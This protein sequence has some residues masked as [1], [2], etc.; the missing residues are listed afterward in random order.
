MTPPPII[1]HTRLV[2]HLR[3]SGHTIT[4]DAALLA[5]VQA[6][7]AKY[8]VRLPAAVRE[9]LTIA[10]FK[11]LF[12]QS[13]SNNDSLLDVR[14]KYGWQKY[15]DKI[16]VLV[17]ENQGVCYWVGVLDGNDDPPVYLQWDTPQTN[18][19]QSKDCGRL[20]DFIYTWVWDHDL[21][22]EYSSHGYPMLDFEH[23][24]PLPPLYR[25][26]NAQFSMIASGP[27]CFVDLWEGVLIERYEDVRSGRFAQVIRDN[28]ARQ[29]VL[30]ARPLPNS[31]AYALN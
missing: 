6:F 4:T 5:D 29:V 1:Y 11:M 14:R 15:S 24:G 22:S 27:D 17:T 3:R 30:G 23:R 7:E 26:L 10:Q 13:H 25:Y 12:E 21:V 2:E 8:S 16:L 31:H 9:L 20:S 28:L 18:F 19:D